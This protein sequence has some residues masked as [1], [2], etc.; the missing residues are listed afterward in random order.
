MSITTNMLIKKLTKEKESDITN[1]RLAELFPEALIDDK[2]VLDNI[3]F[4]AIAAVLDNVNELR[5]IDFSNCI[6]INCDFSYLD[7]V[8]CSGVEGE[9]DSSNILN[10]AKGSFIPSLKNISS[11][12]EE[13]TFSML[14]C[15][16]IDSFERQTL[17]KKR[18][19]EK[20]PDFFFN[21]IYQSIV[22][23]IDSYILNR[24]SNVVGISEFIDFDFDSPFPENSFR[25]WKLHFAVDPAFSEIVFPLVAPIISKYAPHF[26]AALL[27]LYDRDRLLKHLSNS[28]L[29]F[30]GYT[31]FSN[32]VIFSREELE[33]TIEEFTKVNRRIFLNAQ[34]TIYLEKDHELIITSNNL[35][36][37]MKE[38]EAVL[39]D[40]DIPPPTTT[41]MSDAKTF[42]PFFSIRNDKIVRVSFDSSFN[43]DYISAE[44]TGN[45]YNPSHLP[46][47][48]QLLLASPNIQSFDLVAHYHRFPKGDKLDICNNLMNCIFAYLMMHTNV[49]DLNNAQFKLF[50][51][52]L[53]KVSPK[54]E[55]LKEY[56]KQSDSLKDDE[57]IETINGLKLIGLHFEYNQNRKTTPD[58]GDNLLVNFADEIP[59]LLASWPLNPEFQN[60]LRCYGNDLLQLNKSIDQDL[61]GTKEK[62]YSYSRSTMF[63]RSHYKLEATSGFVL[64]GYY[65]LDF[66]DTH[67]MVKLSLYFPKDQM[68]KLFDIIGDIPYQI[69]KTRNGNLNLI[70]N[71]S[72]KLIEQ[73]INK[74][75]ENLCEILTLDLKEKLNHNNMMRLGQ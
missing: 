39:Q 69:I 14:R 24:N 26:K 74:D 27:P 19:W 6:I 7:L 23:N 3:N 32:Q 2:L 49:L 59:M 56:I 10:G 29:E 4:L 34:L 18:L 72:Y 68:A 45:N 63:F 70:L 41:A 1:F 28:N 52:K 43:Y 54:I 38:V 65:K 37:M 50:I 46:N 42:S 31:I 9:L 60:L 61:E 40:Q 13:D 25:G 47:P 33:S 44:K 22:K 53:F 30:P 16:M 8:N 5:G 67:N 15:A 73:G 64:D 58:F 17:F 20:Y 66:D 35:E 12:S 11:E 71:I 62:S 48:Y 51:K 75:L 57:L 55:Q 36:K 21:F